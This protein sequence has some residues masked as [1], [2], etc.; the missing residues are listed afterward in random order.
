MK[1]DFIQSLESGKK[2]VVEGNE[3]RKA[4]EII[5]AIYKSAEKNCE[6]FL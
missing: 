1:R 5:L 3:G 4:I 2:S 6:V